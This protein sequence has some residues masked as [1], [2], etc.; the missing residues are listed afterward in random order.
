VA[1]GLRD[2]FP[3]PYGTDDAHRWV[4]E[5]TSARVPTNLAIEVDG[6]A[7]G[8]IGLHRQTDVFQ[9]SAELGYWLGETHWGKGIMSEAVR[10]FTAFAL[11]ESDLE[12]IY[13]TVFETNPASAR[14]L[15]KAGYD[16]E[17]RLRRHVTKGG[18]T[19]DVLFYGI[20]RPSRQPRVPA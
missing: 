14:V 2:A 20:V 7:C 8:G 5:M 9:K 17:G 16:L 15:V 13:A 10:G 1:Q 11:R 19:M 3:Q 12:H 18:V 6:E 4:R